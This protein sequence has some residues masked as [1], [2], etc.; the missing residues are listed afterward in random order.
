MQLDKAQTQI[1][2]HTWDNATPV[3]SRSGATHIGNI[4]SQEYAL[5]L[6]GSLGFNPCRYEDE[7]D[8][9]YRARII[10]EF[11]EGERCLA[12]LT[13][14]CEEHLECLWAETVQLEVEAC[15]IEANWAWLQE[16]NQV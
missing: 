15:A 6:T 10:P 4:N 9:M 16:E 3:P 12:D 1:E 2:N 11:E 7:I 8:S 5:N 13:K 14:C